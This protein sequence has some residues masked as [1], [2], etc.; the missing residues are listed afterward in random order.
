MDSKVVICQRCYLDLKMNGH[1]IRSFGG[2][3]VLAE[4]RD[5]DMGVYITSQVGTGGTVPPK[6]SDEKGFG[7]NHED[8]RTRFLKSIIKFG[9]LFARMRVT[10]PSKY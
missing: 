7:Q 8:I 4:C 9:L 2:H 3:G 10:S 6:Y 1:N 5:N